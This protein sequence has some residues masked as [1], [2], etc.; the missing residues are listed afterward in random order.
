MS[1]DRVFPHLSIQNYLLVYMHQQKKSQ[2]KAQTGLYSVSTVE[3]LPIRW[4][5]LFSLRT[6]GPT[7]LILTTR[8]RSQALTLT[9]E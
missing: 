7:G 1:Y 3:K 8:L 6:T 4:I 9:F 2:Q 5:A